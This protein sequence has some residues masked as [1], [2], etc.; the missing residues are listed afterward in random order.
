MVALRYKKAT[1]SD[2][3]LIYQ[4]AEE[5]WIPTFAPFFSQKQLRALF[6]G[7]YNDKLLT[8][9]LSQTE[10][11]FYFLYLNSE[12]IGYMGVENHDEFLKLDKIYIHPSLQ[13]KGLGNQAMQKV[14]KLARAAKLTEIRLRV[15]R[16]N[17]S[18]ITFYKNRNYTITESID[19]PGPNGFIY[20][21]YIMIKSLE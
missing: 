21:D 20:E 17:K 5:I 4:L 14:E 16:G 13:G 7:M 1:R 11:E 12:P 18:A 15:N 3:P 9:W 6:T 19:F 2:L 8:T 10:N